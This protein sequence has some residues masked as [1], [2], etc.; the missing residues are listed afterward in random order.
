MADG[1]EQE[2]LDILRQQ[3]ASLSWTPSKPGD[4]QRFLA[5]FLPDAV[6]FPS[7]RPVRKQSTA[8][9]VQ[10]MTDLAKGSLATF[11]EK[12]LGTRILVFGNVAVAVAG[13]EVV[14]NEAT[15]SR[16]VEMALLVREAGSWKI[17]AQAWDNESR[18]NRLPAYLEGPHETL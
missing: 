1:D 9:F 13:S 7:A 2:I 8:E 14:E 17:A 16:G 15:V 6:L 12:L 5:V 18:A 3:Y 11:D 4:W 10:R